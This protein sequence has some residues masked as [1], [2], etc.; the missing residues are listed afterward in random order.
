MK[1]NEPDYSWAWELTPRSTTTHLIIH[2]SAGSGSPQA[3]HEYHR[4]LG[5][6]GIAYHYYIRRDG[7]IWRG[8][9]EEAR[10][11]HTT[12]WNWCSI[13]VCFEGNFEEEEMSDA[14]LKAGQEL[15]EDIIRR[16]PSISVGK[17]SEFQL[18]AC[19]GKNFPYE[20]MLSGEPSGSA[21]DSEAPSDWAAQACARMT[22]KG[23]F[24][25]DGTGNFR[26]HQAIT[27]QEAAVILDRLISGD[28]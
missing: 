13:G 16:R 7:E 28:N 19:P 18:T 23:V 22:E 3:V 9:P 10:G 26:W 2:H 20:T 5:W 1:I 21:E 6:A 24:K 27:R 25:G 15:I 4:S 17:H 12:N 11:G 14:Q 8:R